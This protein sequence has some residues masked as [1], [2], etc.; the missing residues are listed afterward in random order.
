MQF[1][2][3]RIAEL[4]GF[5]GIA[6]LMVLL[7]HFIGAV[8]TPNLEFF[9]ILVKGTLILGRTGVDL[10][11]VLSG[12]LII[13]ILID[14]RESPNLLRVFYIRRAARILPPY[15]L[16]IGIFW[17]IG[18]FVQPGYY[19]GDSVPW[20]YYLTFTQNWW[21]SINNEWG[22]AASSVTWSVAIEE[23]F[24]VV[25]PAIVL[26]TPPHYLKR[27][28][29]TLAVASVVARAGFHYLYPSLGFAPYVNT[30]LRLDGLCVGGLI[31]IVSRNPANMN[32]LKEN[33]RALAC[34]VLFISAILPI[35][36]WGI[37]VSPQDTMYYWGHIYLAVLYGTLLVFTI[38]HK[39]TTR[40]A[41]LRGP[42]L[43]FFGS[44]SYSAYLFHPLIIGI[45]F[46]LDGRKEALSSIR[47]AT[48]LAASFVTTMVFCWMLLRLV[49]SKAMAWGHTFKYQPTKDRSISSFGPSIFGKS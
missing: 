41:I 7:W 8:I 3:Q 19:F 29:V 38:V 4:D 10:F 1:S 16:L 5:R 48:L 36:M 9:S 6:V 13:G 20:R 43:R 33:P 28:L 12:F 18:W 46:M 44:I 42:T 27:V 35:F 15:L 11:F 45:F 2:D 49:E 39:N 22:P 14:Q 26:V 23:Q 34:S 24:Y 17:A 37:N 21:M 25:F 40:T 32:Y 47:D 30:F 31:A